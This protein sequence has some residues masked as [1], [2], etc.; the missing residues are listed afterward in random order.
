MHG[1]EERVG[2]VPVNVLSAVTMVAIGIHYRHAVN[3]VGLAQ[4]LDHYS[5]DVDIAEASS[6]VHHSHGVMA[7]RTN[8]GKT[9]FDIL[10]ENLHADSLRAAGAYQVRFGDHA[11][12]IRNAEVDPLNI[13]S[14]G[15]IR[16]EF[17]DPFN[18]EN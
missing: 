17:H 4:V 15:N 12:L 14:R 2:I 3:P 6:P 16:F 8:Q 9:A 5:F 11:Q 7:G 1:Y 13:L 10:F 18:V